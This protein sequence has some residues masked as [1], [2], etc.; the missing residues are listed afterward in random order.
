MKRRP[1]KQS[2]K[3]EL[4]SRLSGELETAMR[5]QRVASEAATHEEARPEDD[6]DTR[7]LEQSYLARGQARR[8]EEL[9]KQV[10]EVRQMPARP[11]AP[12]SAIAVG[13]LIE[14]EEGGA[15]LLLF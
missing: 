1:S 7:A 15:R 8:V 3:E 13:A 10:A 2:L 5:A 6:K 12:T 9:R 11:L 4:A 14:T